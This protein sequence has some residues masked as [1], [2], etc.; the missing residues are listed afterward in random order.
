MADGQPAIQPSGSATE[1]PLCRALFPVAMDRQ[2]FIPQNQVSFNLISSPRHKTRRPDLHPAPSNLNSSSK[3]GSPP[4]PPDSAAAPRPSPPRSAS[5]SRATSSTES[6]RCRS[7]RFALA[8]GSCRS[9]PGF[10]M[11]RCRRFRP[12]GRRGARCRGRGRGARG[13]AGF[14]RSHLVR[15]WIAD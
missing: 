10:G 5:N 6:R 11:R 1:S 2:H 4:P 15:T 12:D 3:T 9:A 8:G 13:R 7:T 14:G